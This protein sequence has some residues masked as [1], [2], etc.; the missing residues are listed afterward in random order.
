VLTATQIAWYKD[1]G[2]AKEGWPPR[3]VLPLEG[4]TMTPNAEEGSLLVVGAD[5]RELFVSN[6]EPSDALVV[7]SEQLARH[8]TAQT[9]AAEAARCTLL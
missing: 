9:E 6:F 3:G 8:C 5:G 2:A 4:A 7:W 1:D